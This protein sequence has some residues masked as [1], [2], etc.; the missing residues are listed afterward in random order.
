MGFR[1]AVVPAGNVPL[2]DGAPGIELEPVATVHEV[3]D[4]LFGRQA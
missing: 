4:M 2:V 3:S 1:R